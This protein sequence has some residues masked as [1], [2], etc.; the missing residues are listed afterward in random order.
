MCPELDDSF[1]K[2]ILT[3]LNAVSNKEDKTENNSQPHI[4]SE[5]VINQFIKSLK[6]ASTKYKEPSDVKRFRTFSSELGEKRDIL[7]LPADRLNSLLSNFFMKARR[8]DGKLYEPDTL[9]SLCR[10]L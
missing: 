2:D 5:Q 4:E 10:S 6:P 8:Y 3:A 7:D 1:N 9:S